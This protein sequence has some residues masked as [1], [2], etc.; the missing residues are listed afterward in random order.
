MRPAFVTALAPTWLD[1]AMRSSQPSVC[2][3]HPAPHDTVALDVTT[4]AAGESRLQEVELDACELSAAE[5]GAYTSLGCMACSNR[6]VAGE[7]AHNVAKSRIQ[8][9]TYV[10]AFFIPV[11]EVL[12][13]SR[14]VSR[15]K[16]CQAPLWPS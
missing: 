12:T 4:R 3:L 16:C 1:D 13:Y 10:Y 9:V 5:L 14:L 6:G 8:H 11:N 15:V 7:F 2:T